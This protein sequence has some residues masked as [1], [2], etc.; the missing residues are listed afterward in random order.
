MSNKVN[1]ILKNGHKMGQNGH[2]MMGQ[3]LDNKKIASS[4]KIT[5]DAHM[6]RLN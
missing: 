4:K 1:D 2:I 3:K 5:N 6:L